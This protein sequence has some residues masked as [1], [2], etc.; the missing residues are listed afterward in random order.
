MLQFT[1]TTEHNR[2]RNVGS[3]Y[4]ES[5]WKN[6][7]S[8]SVCFEAVFV[9]TLQQYMYE[10]FIPHCRQFLQIYSSDP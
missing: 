10:K 6:G 5:S 1:F 7:T 8:I 2:K 3:V 9:F 4:L